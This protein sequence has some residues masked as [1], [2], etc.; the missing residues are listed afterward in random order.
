MH[1]AQKGVRCAGS[2]WPVTQRLRS[3]LRAPNGATLVKSEAL[4]EEISIGSSG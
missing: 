3:G 4:E 1:V 2:V